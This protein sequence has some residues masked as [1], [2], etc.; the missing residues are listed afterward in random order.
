MVYRS[1]CQGGRELCALA[2][3]HVVPERQPGFERVAWFVLVYGNDTFVFF[4]DETAVDDGADLK[5]GKIAEVSLG[6]ENFHGVMVHIPR[7]C[8]RKQL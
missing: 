1:C 6:V 5:D 4:D 3:S 7:V 8:Q 2:L